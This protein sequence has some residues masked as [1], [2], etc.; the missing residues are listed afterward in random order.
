MGNEEDTLAVI[1]LA[2]RKVNEFFDEMRQYFASKV[3]D[4]AE[5]ASLRSALVSEPVD[6]E[7]AMLDLKPL[8]GG[9]RETE[10]LTG[11]TYRWPD[12]N[13]DEYSRLVRF[14]GSGDFE[15]M[16]LGL[17]YKVGGDTIGF[18]FSSDG[19][20][21][22][23]IVYFQAAD[24]FDETAEVVSMIRGNGLT[25]RRGFSP[26]E[27]RPP[28]YADFK[29]ESLKDRVSGPGKWNVLAVVAKVSDTDT[30]LDHTALQARLRGL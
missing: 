27:P 26:E 24:D 22:R 5:K 30:M 15:G 20:S 16:N 25:G 7:N 19:K 11:Q 29:L 12:G 17:G 9:W 28:A 14:S 18:V 10:T 1:D 3:S 6:T 13:I 23:G 8:V 21:K 4:E 2:Q